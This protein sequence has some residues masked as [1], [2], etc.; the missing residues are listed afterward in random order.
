MLDFDIEFYNPVAKTK[1]KKLRAILT[2]TSQSII[3]TTKAEARI[4]MIMT[5]SQLIKGCKWL[6]HAQ[7]CKPNPKSIPD[8][9]NPIPK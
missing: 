2:N 5:K 7:C 3:K 4:L 8:I 6:E 9:D 1:Y